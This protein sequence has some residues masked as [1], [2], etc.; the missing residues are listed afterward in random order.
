MTDPLRHPDLTS[1]GRELRDRLDETLEAE[2]AAARAAAIRRQTL[3]DRLLAAE[4]GGRR[5]VVSCVNGL[6][7]GG[8]V[9]SV[10]VDHIELGHEG[11]G[12]LIAISHIVM[13]EW[14]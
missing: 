6:T 4:D 11:T 9:S 5:V 14:R 8:T 13:L 3:R 7:C 12:R 10:G 1:L 2:Q